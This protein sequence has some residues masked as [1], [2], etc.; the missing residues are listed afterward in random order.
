MTCLHSTPGAFNYGLARA[1]DYA[2]IAWP[3]KYGRG[4]TSSSRRSRG[5]AIPCRSPIPSNLQR[6]LQHRNSP[7]AG[8]SYALW[9]TNPA[10]FGRYDYA[11]WTWDTYG[12]WSATW[13]AGWSQNKP[14]SYPSVPWRAIYFKP[15][16]SRPA[17]A[18]LA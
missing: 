5:S 3:P 4:G 2:P 18:A 14:G 9:Q 1:Y 10:N 15:L 16:G 13:P 8:V 11:L 6:N 17:T 7:P 12:N